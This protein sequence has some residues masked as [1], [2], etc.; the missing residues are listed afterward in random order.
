MEDRPK[1]KIDLTTTD[2]VF[3]ILS[4]VAIVTIWVLTIANYSKL[5]D[6]IATHFNALGKADGFGGKTTI[7]TLPIVAT[8]LFFVMT[9]LNVS[10]KYPKNLTMDNALQRYTIATRM[11]RYFKLAIVIIFG[12]I[13]FQ[14][15]QNGTGQSHGFGTWFLLSD[16]GLVF[17][18]LTYFIVK[19]VKT[20]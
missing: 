4:C 1:I 5:P 8:V 13:V 2:K 12:L 18:P 10:L 7:L 3:D 20:K 15:I 16:L 11:I 17:I 9:I 14:T 19:L 6:T